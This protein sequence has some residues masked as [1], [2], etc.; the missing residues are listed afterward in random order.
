M[1]APESRCM[2][3]C[4]ANGKRQT[5]PGL[6]AAEVHAIDELKQYR[7]LLLKDLKAV[8]TM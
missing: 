1:A 7:E 6:R 3:K 4:A 8:L 2:A 5:N